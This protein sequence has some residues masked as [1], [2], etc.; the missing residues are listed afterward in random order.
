[1]RYLNYILNFLLSN[2][3]G[4]TT[5]LIKKIAA[6]NDCY[7][8][9]RYAD[10]IKSELREVKDKCITLDQLLTADGIPPKPILFE[11]TAIK[12]LVE[13]YKQQYEELHNQNVGRDIALLN[14]KR[15]IG[16]FENLGLKI[17]QASN[18]PKY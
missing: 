5:T 15:A 4:G 12:H 1:M 7:I 9:V 11:T 3:R 8:I 18:Q 2:R 14:I 16:Q 17:G 6:E 10:D 13:T